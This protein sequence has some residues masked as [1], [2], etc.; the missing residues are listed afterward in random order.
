MGYRENEREREGERKR[1]RE[2][3]RERER[4]RENADGHHTSFTSPAF[5]HRTK[6]KSVYLYSLKTDKF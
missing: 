5:F 4:E 3:Q 2:R 1:E 6:V